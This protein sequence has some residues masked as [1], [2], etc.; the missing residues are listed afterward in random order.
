MMRGS[1]VVD[2]R[3]DIGFVGP[4]SDVEKLAKHLTRD[5]DLIDRQC[6]DVVGPSREERSVKP[7]QGAVPASEIADHLTIQEVQ[8]R[9]SP[10][11]D[12]H[13]IASGPLQGLDSSFDECRSIETIDGLVLSESP[14]LTAGQDETFG[15]HEVVGI[16]PGSS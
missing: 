9:R 1:S 2:D 12:D 10:V 7:V 6:H 14:A 13:S 3:D 5:E 4:A 15:G 16:P 11:Q 8:I